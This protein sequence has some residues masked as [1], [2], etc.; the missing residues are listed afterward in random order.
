M[1]ITTTLYFVLFN[2]NVE[3]FINKLSDAA[4]ESLLLKK[5]NLDKFQHDTSDQ[6]KQLRVETFLHLP[7]FI[8][9]VRKGDFYDKK[10]VDKVMNQHHRD[11][12][13]LQ[14]F[15]ILLMIVFGF[16]MENKYLRLPAGASIFL[17]VYRCICFLLFYYL[18]VSRLANYGV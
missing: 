2:Q 15:L 5:I 11:A 17:I 9:L 16:F 6:I 12:F 1:M 18:Q 13:I 10:L 14:L 8:K 3:T 4:K 7:F